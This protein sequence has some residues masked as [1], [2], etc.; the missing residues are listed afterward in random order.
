MLEAI[1]IIKSYV[2]NLYA[3]LNE[4]KLQIGQYRATELQINEAI[5]KTKDGCDKI[6]EAAS[7]IHESIEGSKKQSKLSTD[8]NVRA[9]CYGNVVNTLSS[10]LSECQQKKKLKMQ[11]AE[12]ISNEIQALRRAY[13]F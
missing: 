9:N 6:R 10:M 2:S 8:L 13:S 1:D 5:N 7:I 12:E 4:L 3:E 11:R